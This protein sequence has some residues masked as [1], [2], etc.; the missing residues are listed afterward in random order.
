[1]ENLLEKQNDFTS[2]EE[3]RLRKEKVLTDIREDS[4]QINKLWSDLFRDDT[5]RKKGIT[6]SSVI[7][8]GMSFMDGFLLVW[9]LY[10]KFK[11]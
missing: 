11:K 2:L 9:K 3:I 1:M 7:N 4:R 10:K 8:T 5:P 6:L